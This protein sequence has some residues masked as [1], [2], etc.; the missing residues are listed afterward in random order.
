M[1]AMEPLGREEQTHSTLLQMLLWSSLWT[2]LLVL[3]KTDQCVYVLEPRAEAG[4][5]VYIRLQSES[6]KP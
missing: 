1:Q 6:I 2:C 3:L 5:E 4:K